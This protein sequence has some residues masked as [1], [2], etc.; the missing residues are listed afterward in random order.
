MSNLIRSRKSRVAAVVATAAVSMGMIAAPASAQPQ[1]GLVNVDVDVRNVL[2]DNQV[3]VAVPIN[4]AAN[5]CGVSVE[6]LTIDFQNN[7]NDG[8]ATCT[9][10]ADQ[11][12][13]LSQEQRP[14]RTDR[15]Q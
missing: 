7:E 5:I 9:A 10:D 15:P 1:V 8:I 11:Q 12:V 13:E 6:A 3:Q 4:A 14:G 2:N